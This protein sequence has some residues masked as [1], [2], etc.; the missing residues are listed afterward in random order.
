M[1]NLTLNVRSGYKGRSDIDLVATYRTPKDLNELVSYCSHKSH[2]LFLSP[3]GRARIAKVNGM[4]RRWKRDPN[5]IEI[6]LKY[7]LKGPHFTFTLADIDKVLIPSTP[8]A[9]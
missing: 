8:V 1:P 3:D 2:I 4:V 5:R 7:G 6:P 9:P